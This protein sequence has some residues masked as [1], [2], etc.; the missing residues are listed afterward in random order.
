MKTIEYFAAE[1]RVTKTGS[2]FAIRVKVLGQWRDI[3]EL[4][5]DVVCVLE[6]SKLVSPV[7]RL[8]GGLIVV[9]KRTKTSNSGL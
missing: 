5:S 3:N 9:L 2:D 1:A 6:Q 4:S 7:E 8:Y